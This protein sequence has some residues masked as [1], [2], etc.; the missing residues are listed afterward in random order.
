MSFEQYDKILKIN[1]DKRMNNNI[2]SRNGLNEI[3]PN[4]ILL[5][6]DYRNIIGKFKKAQT[7]LRDLYRLDSRSSILIILI[8]V[9]HKIIRSNFHISFFNKTIAL[10]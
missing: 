5:G 8:Q 6:A 3:N 9:N 10:P 7:T 2:L 1:F 4:G